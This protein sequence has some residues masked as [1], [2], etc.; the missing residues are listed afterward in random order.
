VSFRGSPV[1]GLPV[2]IALGLP[3]GPS[4]FAIVTEATP[5]TALRVEEVHGILDLGAAEVFQLP[6]RTILPQP[7]PFVGAIVDQGRIALELAV[8]TLGWAP[9][10]PARELAGPPPELD[11]STGRELLFKRGARTFAVPIQLLAQVLDRPSISPV[12]LAPSAHRGLLYH[13]RAIH[14]VFDVPVLYGDAVPLG[15]ST[16]LLIEAGENAIAV[17]ADAI[18]PAGAVPDAAPARPSWDVLF[19]S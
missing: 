12:P 8:P 4:R 1:G 16:A 11:F 2:A 13:G 5:P 14:P 10:E 18:L 3:A 17:L 6:V 9:I 19:S 7:A 15:A